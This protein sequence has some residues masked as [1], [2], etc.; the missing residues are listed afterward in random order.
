MMDG[1]GAITW[2]GFSPALDLQGKYQSLS[3]NVEDLKINENST[4][5]K[6]KRAFLVVG[7]GDCRHILKTIVYACRHGQTDLDSFQ[8]FLT[9]F[10]S[11]SCNNTINLTIARADGGTQQ[12][13]FEQE[14]TELFLELFGN[15]LVRPQTSEYLQQ[16]SS[17]FIRFITDL[18]YLEASLPV[19]N[20]SELKFKER[21]QLESIFKFWRNPDPKLFDICQHWEE[22][23]RQYF[24]TRYDSRKNIY[25]WD[26]NMKLSKKVSII[27][28]NEYKSWR[29]QGVAFELRSDSTY[30]VS[31]R[32]LASGLIIK[33]DGERFAR[34]GYW[35]DVVNSPYLA[36]GI[37]SEEKSL[38]KTSNGQHVKTSTL[39]SEYN[40]TALMHELMTGE[41][42]ALPQT[43]EKKE[44]KKGKATLEE[45]AEEE[46]EEETEK[47]GKEIQQGANTKKH[48]V[49]QAQGYVKCPGVKVHFLPVNC[50]P[51]LSR[52][53]KY[54]KL[55]DVIYFSNSM[56]HLL[57]PEVN[58][59]FADEAIIVAETTKFMLDLRPEQMQEYVK[60]ITSMAQ[61]AGCKASGNI[62]GEK[63]A[64]AFFTFKR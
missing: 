46:E 42:Y 21:D 14:K 12:G 52:K 7:A 16:K 37:E 41:M 22:R 17:D 63:D 51:D 38:F 49:C 13:G 10:P 4:T 60:K 55:F 1:F 23:L 24:A 48:S 31:N 35:G 39:V 56:V 64:H 28:G 47:E 6:G 11:N 62:D 33:R 20:F 57:T 25:D 36:F 44:A 61:R 2:W 9:P 58:E 54:S 15:S 19:F 43:D 3:S 27:H 53:S 18:D 34:R 40:V 5:K 30:E 45:L 59:I 50:V 32:T 8:L 26:Y 29:E